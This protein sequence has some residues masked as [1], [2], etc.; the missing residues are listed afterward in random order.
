MLV[1]P[2]VAVGNGGA[3][4]YAVDLV[5]C[6]EKRRASKSKVYIERKRAKTCHFIIDKDVIKFVQYR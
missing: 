3:L 6:V 1:V 5:A 2:R 4:C